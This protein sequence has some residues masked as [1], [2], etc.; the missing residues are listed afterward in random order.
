[1]GRLI[2]LIILSIGKEVY[3][4]AD[5]ST[6]ISSLPIRVGSTY[7]PPDLAY[8]ALHWGESPGDS[9]PHLGLP[10]ISDFL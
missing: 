4:S 5:I 8:L 10:I 1:M 9:L 7:Q 2:F 6:C 3:T